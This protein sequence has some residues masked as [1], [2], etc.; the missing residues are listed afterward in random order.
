[1]SHNDC[2]P[3]DDMRSEYDFR[4]GIRGKYFERYHA[5]VAVRPS[6][7]IDD[8]PFIA[9]FT[10]GSTQFGEVTYMP[11]SPMPQPSPDVQVGTLEETAS[12]R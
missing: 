4:Y 2:D 7:V 10:N 5:Q 8:S 1:M 11:Q 3:R 6:V 9:Q 12:H